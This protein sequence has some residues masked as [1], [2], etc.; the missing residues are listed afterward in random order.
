MEPPEVIET[1]GGKTTRW[2][3]LTAALC[4]QTPVSQSFG[5][6]LPKA[7]FTW[8]FGEGEFS[9]VSLY[10]GWGSQETSQPMLSWKETASSH[11]Q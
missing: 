6:V 10:T 3:A 9:V 11:R 5:N 4:P 7:A 2:V 8:C 1:A